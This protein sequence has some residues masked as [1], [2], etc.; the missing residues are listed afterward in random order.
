M[1]SSNI[2]LKSSSLGSLFEIIRVSFVFCIPR[3]FDPTTRVHAK[4]IGHR[5]KE[6]C[7]DYRSE[8]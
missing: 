6:E 1:A 8:K 4:Q 2:A 7:G 5:K 3:H